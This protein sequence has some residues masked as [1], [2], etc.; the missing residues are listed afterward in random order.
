MTSYV[1]RVYDASNPMHQPK[2]NR[3][4]GACGSC[5]AGVKTGQGTF[6]NTGNRTVVMHLPGQC[7]ERPA[8]APRPNKYAGTCVG[9]ANRVDAGEGVT[10]K[11]E[12]RWVVNHLPGQCPARPA[13][14]APAKD[15]AVAATR[16]NLYPGSCADCGE[17]VEAEAGRRVKPDGG[18]WQAAHLTGGCPPPLPEGVDDGYYAT[19][20]ATGNNDLDFWRVSRNDAGRIK[21]QRV[22][23]GHADT[24]VNRT[25]GHAALTAIL[26][27]GTEAAGKRYADELERC[28]HCTLT[29][30]DDASRA[31][32]K[33][34][35]CADHHG[36][37]DEWRRLDRE[38]R[39]AAKALA[40]V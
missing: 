28:M 40:A 31:L 32:G 24:P 7:P 33:G 36:Q 12:G 20:S 18:R 38:F 26:A 15:E 17:W 1:G 34:Q 14:P 21:V 9:C 29:L 25:V 22:I 2:P 27:A 35:D 30:T 19:I 16:P 37:G 10:T 23:G 3:F 8:P 39:A 5:G 11:V 4:G 6:V 13:R